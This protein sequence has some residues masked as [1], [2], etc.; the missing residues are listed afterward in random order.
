VIYFPREGKV[1]SNTEAFLAGLNQVPGVVK[2]TSIAQSMVGN[3]NT[4]EIHWDGKDPEQRIPFAVRP[5]NY[6]VI[7]MLALPIVAGRSFSR[8]FATDSSAVIFNEAG[9]RA[10]GMDDPIGKQISFR[11]GWK[12][13]IIGVVKDFHYES[14]H[15][16]VAPMFFA[17]KPEY[18]ETIIAKIGAGDVDGTLARIREHYQGFN[19]GFPFEFRFL[20]QDY[21]ALYGA[22]VRVARLSRYFAGIAILISCLGLLG[23][24][25]FTAERRRKEIGIRKVLGST[26][27]NIVYMISADFTKLVLVAIL[28]AVP[29]SYLLVKQWLSSF[30]FRIPLEWWY[31][32][33]AGFIALLIAW[34]T[35]GTQAVRA[36]RIN[37]TQCLRDE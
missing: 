31:F 4:T 6:D 17:L 11:N 26:E 16:T 15:A 28:I 7:E 10:M 29:M 9:I 3:G 32:F 14:M 37:P 21:Q 30:A 36:S 12:F 1:R 13:T 8:E 19:P 25:A 27:L 35:V 24:A 34:I 33:G 5:V 18:T 23:L 22:E 20:D 2:A